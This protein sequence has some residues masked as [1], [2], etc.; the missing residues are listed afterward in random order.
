[1]HIGNLTSRQLTPLGDELDSQRRAFGKHLI[2]IGVIIRPPRIGD[3]DYESI[4]I[5]TY[6]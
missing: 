6:P 1:L 4:R 2:T 5:R 3:V